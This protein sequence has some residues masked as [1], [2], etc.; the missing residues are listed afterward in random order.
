MNLISIIG[1]NNVGKSSLFYKLSIKN[2][3][4]YNNFKS[5]DLIFNYCFFNKNMIITDTSNFD[6]NFKN[7]LNLEIFNN[8]STLI[9][10]SDLILFIVDVNNIYSNFNKK[11]S[12]LLINNKKNIFLL[13]NKIDLNKNYKYNINKKKLYNL[14][15]D[16]FFISIKKNIG[17]NDLIYSINNKLN[18]KKEINN[19]N[20]L[21]KIKKFIITSNNNKKKI[22]I[23]GKT[24]SGK[25]TLLNSLINN[26]RM[27]VSDIENTTLN[28]IS[29]ENINKNI[30]VT[31]TY[32]IIYKDKYKNKYLFKNILKNIYNH[33]IMLYISS[34]YDLNNNDLNMINLFINNNIYIPLILIINKI[35]LLK[36]KNEIN[37][38]RSNILN[39]LKFVKNKINILFIS[40]MNNIG[41]NKLFFYIKSLNIKKIYNNNNINI[42][43]K[44][45]LDLIII[46]NKNNKKKINFKINNIY[47][48]NNILNIIINNN[49]NINE[50]FKRFIIN[51]INKKIEKG[52]ILKI[53]Y[54]IY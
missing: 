22:I 35:D 42:L 27:L 36:N 47:I 9:N 21:N 3:N 30:I 25:S 29:S 33:N 6:F 53:I 15:Y 52:Y 34:Y 28:I 11:I 2:I 31:D 17:I 44:I 19:S 16:F 38:V 14:K 12:N 48:N 24:N 4:N 46:Y 43:K 26:K 20:Y 40:A 54:K 37:I 5:N 10:N 18:N 49:I 39:K 51:N 45:I 41:I 8:I 50:N 23:I 13:I 1:Y 7:K 32:G